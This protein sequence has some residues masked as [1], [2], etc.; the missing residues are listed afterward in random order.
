ML[1]AKPSNVEKSRFEG[2]TFYDEMSKGLID[3]LE[4]G[5]ETYFTDREKLV[6]RIC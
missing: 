2:F 5:E 3:E 6:S 4:G 1:G